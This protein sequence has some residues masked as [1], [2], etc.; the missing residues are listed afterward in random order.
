MPTESIGSITGGSTGSRSATGGN[1]PAATS[2]AS[3]GAS[4]YS[5]LA[6]MDAAGAD[7]LPLSVLPAANRP[8]LTASR[9]IPR[10]SA[11]YIVPP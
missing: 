7:V 10:M 6:A 5:P 11:L 8:A 2:A 1:S 4:E 9:V 3:I